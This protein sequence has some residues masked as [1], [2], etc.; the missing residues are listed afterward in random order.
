VPW[1]QYRLDEQ[2]GKYAVY[3]MSW[4]PD[5]PDPD[6]YIAPFFGINNFLSSPY[7]NSDIENNLI[8]RTRQQEE[9]SSA[10]SSF[11]QAQNDIAQDVPFL[12][13][14]QSQQYLAAKSDITGTEWAFNASSE[15]QYWELGRGV[16]S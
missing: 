5:F 2:Q 3:G 10:V 15:L 13:L 16:T 9:R 8:P 11:A 12:P 7:T 14:W 6:D 1:Q 4:S